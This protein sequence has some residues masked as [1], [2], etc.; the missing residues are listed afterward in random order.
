MVIASRHSE[1]LPL[2][3]ADDHAVVRAELIA[4][5]AVAMS[6]R[7]LSQVQASK[8]LRTDQPT[9]SKVLRGRTES[10][11]LDK[12]LSWLQALGCSVEIRV[13]PTRRQDGRLTAVMDHRAYAEE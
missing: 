7:D 9:L 11:S 13:G 2:A 10:V 6:R 8:L 12:L 3:V 1:T 5:I 4:A